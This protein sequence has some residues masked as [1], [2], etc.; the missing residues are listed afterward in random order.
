VE[1]EMRTGSM[2]RTHKRVVVPPTA[3]IV[4]MTDD[5]LLVLRAD[6]VEAQQLI[7]TQIAAAR[8]S[9]ALDGDWLIRS[10]GALS[11]MRRGLS[12]IKAEQTRRNGGRP[13]GLAPESVQEGFEALDVIRELLKG[14][15]GVVEAYDRLAAA[16]RAFL[17][18]DSDERFAELER[19]V[20]GV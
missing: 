12:A 11:H 13:P 19:L 1:T 7:E 16:V 6:L 3:D 9:G 4:A 20:D 14:H 18:D 10:N 2:N 8:L 17:D 5:E 15:K